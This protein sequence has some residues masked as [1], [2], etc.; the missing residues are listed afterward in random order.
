MQNWG[1]HVQLRHEM[2]TSNDVP[3]LQTVHADIKLEGKLSIMTESQIRSRTTPAESEISTPT[4]L[5][6]MSNKYRS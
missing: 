1:K 3:E 5:R 2:Q 4:G 6:N